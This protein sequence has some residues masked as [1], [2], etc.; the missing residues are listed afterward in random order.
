M[1]GYLTAGTKEVTV[2]TSLCPAETVSGSE[3]PL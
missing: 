3:V 2:V 1:Y